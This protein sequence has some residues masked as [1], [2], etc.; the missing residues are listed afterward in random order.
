MIERRTGGG[1]PVTRR[2][3]RPADRVCRC[4]MRRVVPSP[5]QR[6]IAAWSSAPVA[7]STPALSWNRLKSRWH[8]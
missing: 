4:V 3:A 8:G 7:V 6:G 2:R 5:L 1:W